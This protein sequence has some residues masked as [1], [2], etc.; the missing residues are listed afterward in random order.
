[1][2]ERSLPCFLLQAGLLIAD[3][4]GG[5]SEDVDGFVRESLPDPVAR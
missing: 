1:V 5:L 4:A 2:L 3:V